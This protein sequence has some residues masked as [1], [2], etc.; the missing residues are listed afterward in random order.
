MG[1]CGV[2]ASYGKNQLLLSIAESTSS[3]FVSKY[4]RKGDKLCHHQLGHYL[5]EYKNGNL[6]EAN[7][8]C[9]NN[10]DFIN[11]GFCISGVFSRWFVTHS[12]KDID[13]NNF[14]QEPCL[15]TLGTSLG[16]CL[17]HKFDHKINE[18]KK[19]RLSYDKFCTGYKELSVACHSAIGSELYAKF[20]KDK[21]IQKSEICPLGSESERWFCIRASMTT[22]LA[23]MTGKPQASQ[24]CKGVSQNELGKRCIEFVKNF[25]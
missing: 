9:L 10:S 8:S 2:L 17:K 22:L 16:S 19:Y 7:K 14:F 20:Q 5:L 11:P 21:D 1:S 25:K 18:L 4:C 6:I 12:S 23:E 24:L 13:L 15:Q 3:Q